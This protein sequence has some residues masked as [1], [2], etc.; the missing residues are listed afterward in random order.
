MV[1][2]RKR[3]AI[4]LV[5]SEGQLRNLSSVC[6]H[7]GT[8]DLVVNLGMA[9]GITGGGMVK[10]PKDSLILGTWSPPL[11]Y[12]ALALYGQAPDS[13]FTVFVD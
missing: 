6:L 8:L 4:W 12:A 9:R 10:F 1:G 3:A 5:S 2:Q 13:A 7:K 11:V